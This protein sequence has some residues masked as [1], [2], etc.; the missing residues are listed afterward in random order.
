LFE[1][2]SE[3]MPQMAQEEEQR[4]FIGSWLDSNRVMGLCFAII[5]SAVLYGVIFFAFRLSDR[6][7]QAP[8]TTGTQAPEFLLTMLVILGAIA[9]LAVLVLMAA[10]FAALNLT[11]PKEA[12]ALPPG[13]V[14]ALIALLLITLF[15]ITAVFTLNQFLSRD[16]A[17]IEMVPGLTQAMVDQ[18]PPENIRAIRPVEGTGRFDVDRVETMPNVTQ[19]S[20]TQIPGEELIAIRPMLEVERLFEPVGLSEGTRTIAQ[21]ILTTVG[22]LVVAIA[23]FYFG[24]RSVEHASQALTPGMQ[25][26]AGPLGAQVHRIDTDPESPKPG[27]T[28]NIVIHGS[29]LGSIQS[30]RF[31]HETS[32][33]YLEKVTASSNSISGELRLG[34]EAPPGSWD[35]IIVL[36]SGTEL[37]RGRAFT[38]EP[39]APPSA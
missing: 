6:L 27:D 26:P 22:T 25:E 17:R 15:T 39:P 28:V 14:R 4:S 30:V 35:L 34:S 12:I 13:T 11:Y 8:E 2:S 20:I 18:I 37:R 33:I 7:I 21:Q 1:K 24:A 19:E 9:L 23:S 5:A 16:T 10:G 32:Q 3:E 29:S 36:Q 38:V 31:V